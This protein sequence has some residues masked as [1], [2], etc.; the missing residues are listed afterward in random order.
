MPVDASGL[1]LVLEG[2]YVMNFDGEERCCPAGSFIFIPE[3]YR[4]DSGSARCRA[5]NSTSIFPAAMTAHFDDLATALARTDI[6][7]EEL[8]EIARAHGRLRSATSSGRS[9]DHD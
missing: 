9:D 1:G 4:T 8:A 6:T 3:A 5:G 2:E 7:D